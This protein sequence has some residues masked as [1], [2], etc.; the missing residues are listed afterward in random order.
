MCTWFLNLLRRIIMCTWKNYHVQQRN[1]FLMACKTTWGHPPFMWFSLLQRI[2][3][4]LVVVPTLPL[5]WSHDR[6]ILSWRLVSV[7]GHN[8]LLER[9]TTCILSVTS[10]RYVLADITEISCS[11]TSGSWHGISSFSITN[12]WFFR[13]NSSSLLCPKSTKRGK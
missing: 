1:F 11:C 7:W 4:I 13:P 10:V 5:P 9:G 6:W 8:N 3:F 2:P 12:L